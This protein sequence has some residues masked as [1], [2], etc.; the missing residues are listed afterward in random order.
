MKATSEKTCERRTSDGGNPSSV[1]AALSKASSTDS[2]ADVLAE[3]Q[4]LSL[5]EK[6]AATQS[7]DVEDVTHAIEKLNCS[8]KDEKLPE[9]HDDHDDGESDKDDEEEEEF[10]TRGPINGIITH[11]ASHIN[12]YGYDIYQGLPDTFYTEGPERQPGVKSSA[13]LDYA[14]MGKAR[15]PLEMHTMNQAQLSGGSSMVYG[16]QPQP[17][18]LLDPDLPDVFDSG[19][20]E[21][22]LNNIANNFATPVPVENNMPQQTALQDPSIAQRQK[23]T[24]KRFHKDDYKQMYSPDSGMGGSPE[25]QDGSGMGGSPEP[26]DGSPSDSP[27]GSPHDS[28]YFSDCASPAGDDSGATPRHRASPELQQLP[29]RQYQQLSSPARPPAP[30]PPHNAPYTQMPLL[31]PN[32]NILESPDTSKQEDIVNWLKCPQVPYPSNIPGEFTYEDVEQVIN[33]DTTSQNLSKEEISHDPALD[34][35]FCDA[36]DLIA[37]DPITTKAPMLGSPAQSPASSSQACYS[38]PVSTTVQPTYMTFPPARN[39]HNPAPH[40]PH[41]MTP[42]GQNQPKPMIQASPNPHPMQNQ[43]VMQNPHMMPTPQSVLPNSQPI[44]GNPAMA[45]G[46]AMAATTLASVLPSQTAVVFSQGIPLQTQ[47]QI[48]IPFTTMGIPTQSTQ[49]PLLPSQRPI[50]PKP[51]TGPTGTNLTMSA[52]Q[53]KYQ[54]AKGN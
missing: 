47:P 7:E 1:K 9:V 46:S 40:N 27:V 10:R 6:T 38:P 4:K 19:E 36:L 50:L 45:P 26:Q 31:E 49:R 44:V 41:P 23:L 53:S 18:T 52:W 29:T 15:R 3:M 12:P 37:H 11:H 51:T 16:N 14:Q 21:Q 24:A 48:I 42:A 2:S 43:A 34:A 13:P 39:L 35:K 25:P 22:M 30:C 17:T 8:G 5:S 28:Q 20:M 54:V 32:L 33:L